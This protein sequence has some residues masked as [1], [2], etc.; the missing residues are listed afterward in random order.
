M[1]NWVH[2]SLLVQP[3]IIESQRTI[4]VLED[5]LRTCVIDFGGYWD[6]FLSLCE[7]SY[8]NIYHSSIDM[9]PFEEPYGKGC[10]SPI[11][12][13]EARDVKPLG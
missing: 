13:F 12:W 11:E 5:M 9:A 10:R 1:K 4:Q 7:F 8:N 6:N 2:N 3:S